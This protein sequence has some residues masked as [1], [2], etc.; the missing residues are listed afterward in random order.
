MTTINPEGVNQWP[1]PPQ[2]TR[3]RQSIA[4]SDQSSEYLSTSHHSSHNTSKPVMCMVDLTHEMAEIKE[5]LAR[6]ANIRA[7]ARQRERE[8]EEETAHSQLRLNN[9]EIALRNVQRDTERRLKRTRL[10]CEHEAELAVEKQQWEQCMP[11]PPHPLGTTE[12]IVNIAQEQKD[13]Q[14]RQGPSCK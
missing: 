5:Q 13:Q 7:D 6:S 10:L 12:K 14:K 4:E 2:E 3:G 11:S 8:A 1:T 9:L